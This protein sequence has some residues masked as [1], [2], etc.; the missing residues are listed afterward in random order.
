MDSEDEMTVVLPSPACSDHAENATKG[1]TAAGGRLH[2]A[3]CSLPHLTN[4]HTATTRRSRFRLP[5]E[6]K[7][8]AIVESMKF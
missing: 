4:L 1:P 7:V 8:L 3:R 5:V 2:G 6:D